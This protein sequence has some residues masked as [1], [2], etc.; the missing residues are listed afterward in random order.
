MWAVLKFRTLFSHK[1]VSWASQW[2]AFRDHAEVSHYYTED[3]FIFVLK[4]C[5]VKWNNI[6][7]NESILNKKGLYNSGKCE[8]LAWS[9]GISEIFNYRTNKKVQHIKMFMTD[10][11]HTLNVEKNSQNNVILVWSTIVLLINKKCCLCSCRLIFFI[12]DFYKKNYIHF[13]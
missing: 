8:G 2:K 1:H 12:R 7:W 3:K 11:N 6:S 10:F 13:M 5:H 9:N 4:G